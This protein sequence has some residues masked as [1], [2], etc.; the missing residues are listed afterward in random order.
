MEKGAVA[1]LVSIIMPTFDSAKYITSSVASVIAQSYT[2]WELIIVDD[3]STDNTAQVVSALLEQDSRISYIR[4]ETN[5][6][7]AVAR[8][9][10][11]ERA[12][13]KYM[14]FLDSDDLWYPEKLEK[15]I[16]FMETNGYNFSC[17]SYEHIN[18]DGSFGGRVVKPFKKADYNLCLYYGDCIGNST[19]VY[20]VEA[21]GK[22]YVP[23]IR[24]RNDFAL[25]LQV[26]K[27][28]KYVYGIKEVLSSYRKRE[29][30]LSQ[31]KLSL[32]KYQ[33]Q[34]YYEI[35]KLGVIK[36]SLAFVTLFVRKVYK[37]IFR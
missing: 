21:L 29:Q 15:Q 33:W 35:E 34:L 24:K 16:S 10:G 8:N 18:E 20:N 36:T 37:R 3:C 12:K 6:G 9:A 17:T 7:A 26:L 14:A 13:G 11:I 27:K 25:W 30:S 32:V 22:F 1:S 4:L 23:Q 31:K 2:D 19:A 28:E 5:S